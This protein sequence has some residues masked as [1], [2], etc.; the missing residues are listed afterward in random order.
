MV[1]GEVS[2]LSD[3]LNDCVVNCT[4]V[5]PFVQMASQTLKVTDKDVEKKGPTPPFVPGKD[6]HWLRLSVGYERK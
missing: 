1:K 2:E 3:V 4:P 5:I 6:L